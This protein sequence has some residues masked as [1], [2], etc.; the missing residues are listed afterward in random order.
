M[1]IQD[2]KCED[3]G[4]SMPKN[5]KDCQSRGRPVGIKDSNVSG[6]PNKNKVCGCRTLWHKGTLHLHW[7]APNNGCS[8]NNGKCDKNGKCVCV[9]KGIEISLLIFCIVT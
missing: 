1:L 5:K 2:G 9:S 4:L 8:K 6:H 7:N 3:Y